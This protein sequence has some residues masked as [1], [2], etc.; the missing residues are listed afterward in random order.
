MKGILC[1]VQLQ[2]ICLACILTGYLL[3]SEVFSQPSFAE[4]MDEESNVN[5]HSGDESGE[6]PKVKP[7]AS[8]LLIAVMKSV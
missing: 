6:G 4:V 5:L 1:I 7:A 3:V 2:Y 8:K